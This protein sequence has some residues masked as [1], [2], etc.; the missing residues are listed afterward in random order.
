MQP[1]EL[2]TYFYENFKY[3]LLSPKCVFTLLEEA[4]ALVKLEKDAQKSEIRRVLLRQSSDGKK[5]EVDRLAEHLVNLAEAMDN[6]D[7]RKQDTTRSVELHSD[8]RRYGL[9]EVFGWLLVAAF[10]AR[11]EQE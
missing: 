5:K 4:P 2:F 9:V 1:I 10:L 11:K 7:R 8:Q 6:D 3:N